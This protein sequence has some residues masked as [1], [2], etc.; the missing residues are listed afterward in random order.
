MIRKRFRSAILT[1]KN[2]PRGFRAA[3]E[4][5]TEINIFNTDDLNCR[6][7]IYKEN[8]A[9]MELRKAKLL[10]PPKERL[11]FLGINVKSYKPTSFIRAQPLRERTIVCIMSDIPKRLGIVGIGSRFTVSGTA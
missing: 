6:F 3:G 5:P 4:S 9:Y 2:A 1:A 8:N 10:P 11:L 7:H